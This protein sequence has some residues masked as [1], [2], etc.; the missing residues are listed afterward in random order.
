MTD[1]LGAEIQIALC[2]TD[3]SAEEFATLSFDKWYCKN[4]CPKEIISNCNKLF[5]S[6]SWKSLMML[7]GVKHK[8]S[9]SFHPETNG[10]SEH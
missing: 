10:S 7:T 2:Q 5:I 3:L 1:C 4:G 6:K 9:T 8:L